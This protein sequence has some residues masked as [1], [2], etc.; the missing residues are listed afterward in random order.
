M[1]ELATQLLLMVVEFG[2]EVVLHVGQGVV[3]VGLRRVVTLKG[4]SVGKFREV[5][6][7]NLGIVLGGLSSLIRVKLSIKFLVPG[8]DSLGHSNP[9]P[10]ILLLVVESPISLS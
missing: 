5:H 3:H 9:S 10:W 1:S 4:W 6:R 8:V 7:G 2:E